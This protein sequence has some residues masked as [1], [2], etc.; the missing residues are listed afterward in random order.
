[1]KPLADRDTTTIV[2]MWCA[3]T[4]EGGD[5][6]A[7]QV[8]RGGK[9]QPVTWSE[10]A[11]DVRRTSAALVTLGVAP[12]DRVVLL[13][14]NRY[15][16]IVC[17]LAIQLARAVHVPI[18]ASFAGP[19][20]SYQIL[21]SGAKL[22]ILSGPDQAQKLVD[23]AAK[24]PRALRFVS[25]D[26]CPTPIGPFAVQHLSELVAKVDDA[27]ATRIEQE[28]REKVGPDDLATI[29][30]TSGT[31]GEPKGVM[32]C[33]KNIASNT[34]AMLSMVAQKDDDVRLTWLPLSHIFAR[35]CDLYTWIAAGGVLALADS[36]EGA[37]ANC[38]E[39]HPT[40]INGV[41]YFWDK[42]E[43][44]LVS[45]GLA[46][47]PGALAGLLGGRARLCCSGGAALPD[48]TAHFFDQQ[49]VF[50]FQGY[51]LTET[52]PTI[53]TCRENEVKLG[54][55]G[56]PMPGIEVKIA[57][58]GEILTRGPHVMVG[59]WN[60]PEATAEVIRDGWFHTGDLGELDDEGYL[61]ITGR[62]K[63]MIVTAA[64]KNISPV[65]LEALLTSDPL[66]AQAFIIGD[67]RNYVSA[68]IVVNPDPLKAEMREL[69]IPFTSI[70]DALTNPE[71]REMYAARIAQ[72]LAGV[73]HYEQV[74]KFTLLEKGFTAESGEMTLTLKLRRKEIEKNYADVIEAMYRKPV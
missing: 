72:R 63:E 14:R 67:A 42:L 47:K 1:V 12:G 69:E 32:L 3:R 16:W 43:R 46:D 53:T 10:M 37:V 41:P 57:D 20:I 27:V 54:T 13:S 15:E 48:H 19:Q 40:L 2:A 59:Y 30:Y 34:T 38:Q 70:R 9:Y 52:S 51:G 35:T 5:R 64:G 21:D 26:P 71:V 44:F 58:D 36:P 7:M 6:T 61:K 11:R 66:I 56:K 55:V 50:L 65:N 45:Q 33:Q 28:A 17:D 18:H 62:K 22:V 39:I 31:T 74:Q 24:F 68:L 25:L 4:Q 49:G 29:L 73:S 8:R 60:K 23:E